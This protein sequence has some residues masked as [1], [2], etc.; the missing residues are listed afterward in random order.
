MKDEKVKNW[1]RRGNN[2]EQFKTVMFVTA[3]PGEKLLKIL[4]ETEAKFRISDDFRIKFV[5]NAGI[6]LKSVQ[7]RKSINDKACNDIVG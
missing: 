6:K 7:K 4:K 2:S 3:T 1:F 5:S